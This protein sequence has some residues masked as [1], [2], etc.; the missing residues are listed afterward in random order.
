MGGPAI[1]QLGFQPPKIKFRGVAAGIGAVYWFF[2]GYRIYHDGGHHFVSFL[3]TKNILFHYSNFVSTFISSF[4]S[5]FSS[6]R[7]IGFPTP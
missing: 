1:K 7:S 4:S 3:P 6:L 2:L 5:Y